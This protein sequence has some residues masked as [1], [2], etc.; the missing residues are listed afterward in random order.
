MNLVTKLLEILCLVELV[1]GSPTQI[2]LRN[3][4]L[5]N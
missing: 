3:I 2:K 5:K 4:Y 1:N